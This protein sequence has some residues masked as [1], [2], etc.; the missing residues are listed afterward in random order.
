MVRSLEV[1]STV[2]R[3]AQFGVTLSDPRLD[4][5]GVQETKNKVVKELVGD[6]ESGLR[7][8]G[9]T[10]F[11]EPASFLSPDELL[12]GGKR[13]RAKRVII[14]TG[15]RPGRPPIP[16]IE[17]AITSDEALELRSLPKSMSIIGGGYIALEL[18][19]VF[20]AA[21][22]DLTILEATDRLLPNADGEISRA[23]EG[24]FVRRGVGVHT[25]AKVGGIS[26]ENDRKVVTAEIGGSELSFHAD[27][28]LVAT[29]RGPK[30][31]GLNLD[32]AG[33]RYSKKGIDVN[34]FMQTSAPSVYAAGDVTGIL[35]LTPVASYQARIAVKNAVEGNSE[36][37]DYR[38]VPSA[39]F[40][41]P[42]IAWVGLTEEQARAENL[43][44]SVSHSYFQDNGAAVVNGEP[45]GFVKLIADS[46]DR[47]IG[48]HII[49]AGA[50]DS[51]ME[52]A[53]AMKG[54]LTIQALS[55]TIHVHPAFSFAVA[56]AAASYRGDSRACYSRNKGNSAPES[57]Q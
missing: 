46:E 25:S 30:V 2:K 40:T 33:I 14:A 19:Y 22:V 49:G 43:D 21:G 15:S 53:V 55:D 4:W 3:A 11:K 51:I 17:H 7:E 47:I 56:R 16:G 48:G 39:V 28:V 1:L 9:I 37:A 35:M 8:A 5:Q 44:Y 57:S 20:S 6:R 54:K 32:A 50:S 10:Y 41:H 13:L 18:G 34:D 38:I 12:I 45:E 23:I 31:E 52:V 42:S 26:L 29:G 36:P 27:T 24:A